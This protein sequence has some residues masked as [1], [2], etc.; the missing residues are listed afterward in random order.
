MSKFKIKNK[1]QNPIHYKNADEIIKE[2]KEHE[3]SNY[4]REFIANER[5]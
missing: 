1:N 2:L 4:I 3:S 5:K